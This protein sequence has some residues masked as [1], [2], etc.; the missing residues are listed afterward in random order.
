[1][2]SSSGTLQVQSIPITALK[3]WNR[4]LEFR[5][6]SKFW[7]LGTEIPQ[8]ALRQVLLQ[9]DSRIPLEFQNFSSPE[10]AEA[11][12]VVAC[13]WLGPEN[14]PVW[15]CHWWPSQIQ[16]PVLQGIQTALYV[17]FMQNID[18]NVNSEQNVNMS[19]P[20]VGS[21][22]GMSEMWSH[23][24]LKG[25]GETGRSQ[26]TLGTTM[27]ASFPDSELQRPGS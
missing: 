20:K 19:R 24:K 9:N 11:W 23:V 14:C 16:F 1:M 5:E 2:D 13:R 27:T 15:C 12:K 18:K 26:V 3:S 7:R 21:A 17:A 8:W 10:I 22:R 6:R 4:P 25:T